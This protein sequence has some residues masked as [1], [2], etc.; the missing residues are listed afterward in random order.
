MDRKRL[1]EYRAIEAAIKSIKK[2]IERTARRI[3]TAKRIPASDS[4]KGSSTEFP[5]IET[6]QRIQ[7]YNIREE[8]KLLA[9]LR[10]KEAELQDEIAKLEEWLEGVEDGLTYS[11]LR[12]KLRNGLSDAEIGRELGY[13]RSRITQIIND[14]LKED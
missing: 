4:V 2:D 6:V 10:R 1:K 11:I 8:E 7:G 13:S 3:D 5:Y 14:Y 9:R 12:L